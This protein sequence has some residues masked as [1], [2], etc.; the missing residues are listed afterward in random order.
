MYRQSVG[1]VTAG[2]PRYGGLFKEREPEAGGIHE[3]CGGEWQV[4]G[5]CYNGTTL[6]IACSK[7]RAWTATRYQT[8]ELQRSQDFDEMRR[9]G[10]A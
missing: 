8:P 3:D 5:V 4:Y 7:C 10:L 1:P 2:N 6:S 9:R